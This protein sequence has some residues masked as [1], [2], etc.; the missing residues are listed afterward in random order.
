MVA[1][2]AQL[3]DMPSAMRFPR[4]EGVGI[5]L[6]ASGQALEIGKGRIIKEG[7]NICLLAFGTRLGE[8]SEAA[9]QLDAQGYKTTVVDARFLKPLD[10]N[11][12]DVLAREHQLIVTIEEGSVGGF[13]SHV[14]NYLTTAGHLD[15]ALKFRSLFLPDSYIDHDAPKK[16]YDL[17]GLNADQI[18]A[19]VL[20][21]IAPNTTKVIDLARKV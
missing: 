18:A 20:K 10:T 6:P 17:A 1:T 4:G 15:G 21:V 9:L 8:A 2:Q 16:M 3:D 7:G 14:A 5:E 13:G 11:L 19:S 12:L